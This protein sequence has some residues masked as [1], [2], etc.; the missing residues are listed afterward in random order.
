MWADEPDVYTSH[1]EFQH[2]YYPSE[3]ENCGHGTYS[4]ECSESENHLQ[5]AYKVN[6]IKYNYSDSLN[7]SYDSQSLSSRTYMRS[8]F[9]LP[10]RL[11][12]NMK[13]MTDESL[14]VAPPREYY[15]FQVNQRQFEV[16]GIK[17]PGNF[18][19]VSSK[20]EMIGLDTVNDRILIK[21]PQYFKITVG[22]GAHQVK[23]RLI[24]PTN[25]LE[26]LYE[27]S[28]SE[29]LA[30]YLKC[31]DSLGLSDS[32]IFLAAVSPKF[33]LSD[34]KS[35]KL[36]SLKISKEMIQGPTRGFKFSLLF[37]LFSQ[38]KEVY[39]VNS[40]PFELWSSCSFPSH[41]NIR[42]YSMDSNEESNSKKLKK[43]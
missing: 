35:L 27:P 13:I 43:K 36:S 10:P 11:S 17:E 16:S 33:N 24:T 32:E 23:D 29:V 22:P 41:L 8:G 6:P 26:L 28:S 14:P 42:E 3:E 31:D 25:E 20:T 34:D 39:R 5:S 9:P 7:R 40:Q 1:L 37:V 19:N 21:A 4:N 15:P 12:M 2:R 38:G 30:V 18:E